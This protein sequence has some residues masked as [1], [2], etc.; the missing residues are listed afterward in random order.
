MSVWPSYVDRATTSRATASRLLST[1]PVARV[2][3]ICWGHECAAG[4]SEG[5]HFVISCLSAKDDRLR[6]WL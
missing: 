4:V 2:A 1:A 6:P 5:G 3:R